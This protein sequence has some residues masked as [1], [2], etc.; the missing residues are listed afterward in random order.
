[1]VAQSSVQ[2]QRIASAEEPEQG[3]LPV[4]ICRIK[5]SSLRIIGTADAV[6]WFF[7][8]EYSRQAGATF[9]F[10]M[11]HSGTIWEKEKAEEF[12]KALCDETG[13]KA[14]GF[15][16]YQITFCKADGSAYT[17]WHL[18][19]EAEGAGKDQKLAVMTRD[20]KIRISDTSFEDRLKITSETIAAAALFSAG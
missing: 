8:P 20:G 14:A 19:L 11:L 18:I 7:K 5:V 17:L 16:P 4:S 10:C 12:E 2:V 13:K 6:H 9:H 3:Y 1:M 15:M